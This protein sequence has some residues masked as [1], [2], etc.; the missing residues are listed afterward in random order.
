VVRRRLGA[1]AAA[2]AQAGFTVVELMVAVTLFALVFAAVAVGMGGVLRVDRTNRSRSVAAYLAAKQVDT[3]RALPFDQVGL[4]RTTQSYTDPGSQSTYSI[5][6]DTQWVTPT[7]NSS[8]CNVPNGSSGGAVAYKRVT[9]RVTWPQMAGAAPVASQTLLTPPTGAYDPYDGHIAVQLYDRNAAPLAG[10]TVTLGGAGTGTQVTGDD[11]CAFFAFLNPGSYTLTLSTSGYVD[12]QLNQP[13]VT[14]LSVVAAQI[15][16]VQVDYDRA[17]SLL[18]SVTSPAGS[19]VPDSFPL[20]LANSNLAVGTKAFTGSGISRTLSPLFPY[21]GGY[22]V[23]T[24]ECTDADPGTYS[25]GNRGPVLATD[26]G[27]SGSGTAALDALDVV[28][29]SGSGT[30]TL[31]SNVTVVAEHVNAVGC[32]A[33]TLTST[34]WVTNAAGTVRLALPYGLWR[35]RAPSKTL[36]TGFSWPTQTLDPVTTTIP[37]VTVRVN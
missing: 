28:V 29:R 34:A 30:G 37:S 6:Q 2:G 17:A 31:T 7:S 33:V 13:S 25:G 35:I 8:S 5:T 14:N 21:A 18:V 11:G 27:G 22:Q 4:G 32:G 20:T 9:V 16:K 1:P 10:Q 26:P 24:G 36:R 3:V 23:W 12:R 15:T 19:V